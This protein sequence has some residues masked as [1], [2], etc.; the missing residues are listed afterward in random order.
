MDFTNLDGPY[1]IHLQWATRQ[2]ADAFP[3]AGPTAGDTETR[4]IF[5]ALTDQLGLV[6]APRSVPLARV[7]IDHVEHPTPD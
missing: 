4:S 1:D 2:L 5:Q 6:L 7:V 3:N